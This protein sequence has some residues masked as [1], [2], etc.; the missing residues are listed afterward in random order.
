MST[1]KKQLHTFSFTVLVV[2]VILAG[3]SV[4]SSAEQ[5][6][7]VGTSSVQPD[8]LTFT[9]SATYS[10]PIV[11]PPGRGKATPNLSLNYN[12][13]N[14]NSWVGMGWS[15][16]IGA[17]QRSTKHG[18]DY[19]ADDYIAIKDG[20]KVE[21]VSKEDD[22]GANHF[23]AKIEGAFTKFKKELDDDFETTGGFYFVVTS[24]DGT[25]FYYG[26]D[27]NSRL[28]GIVNIGEE[29]QIFKWCLD[30][31]VDTNGNTIT[32]SYWKYNYASVVT[33]HPTEIKYSGHEVDGVEDLAPHYSVRF[34]PF[35]DYTTSNYEFSDRPDYFTSFVP[36]MSYSTNHLLSE[37]HILSGTEQVRRYEFGYENEGEVSRAFTTG[38]SRL[39]KITQ[40]GAENKALPPMTFGYQSGGISFP[41]N[42]S[43]K[44][45][46]IEGDGSSRSMTD[47]ATGDINGDGRQDLVAGDNYYNYWFWLDENDGVQWDRH[48]Q[49]S[50]ISEFPSVIKISLMDVNND[51]FDDLIQKYNYAQSYHPAFTIRYGSASAPNSLGER[52][53]PRILD[54][55]KTAGNNYARSKHYD[56]EVQFAD[57]DGDG[58]IDQFGTF[59]N[60]YICMFASIIPIDY[61]LQ[62]LR[63]HVEY[64]VF[65][66]D[67]PVEGDIESNKVGDINGDGLAD[68]LSKGSGY[69]QVHLSNGDGT[70]RTGSQSPS[71]QSGGNW[72]SAL[73]D[74][75]G[76]GL[77]DIIEFNNGTHELEYRVSLGGGKFSSTY[78]Y[79]MPDGDA[80]FA[81][82]NGD[83][84]I[85]LI[86][87]QDCGACEEKEFRISLSTGQF[88]DS[89]FTEPSWQAS[90]PLTLPVD[91]YGSALFSDID[92]DGLTDIWAFYQGRHGELGPN[93]VYMP[94]I[95][96]FNATGL[97][98]D[99]LTT[100]ENGQGAKT[101]ITYAPT[102]S[103]FDTKLPFV[104]QTVSKIKTENL[105][106]SDANVPLTTTYHYKGGKYDFVN[107][108]FLGFEQV[109]QTNP[110]NTYVK[111]NYGE[112]RDNYYLK[113][114]AKDVYTGGNSPAAITLGTF[115]NAPPVPLYTHTSNSWKTSTDLGDSSR[116]V[117]LEEAV[118][119]TFDGAASIVSTVTNTYE[120]NSTYWY[121]KRSR[122]QDSGLGDLTTVNEFV[123]IDEDEGGWDW[124]IKSNTTY[125]G[126]DEVSGTMVRQTTYGYV[127][128]STG[129]VVTKE[130]WL[131]NIIEGQPS[132]PKITM[133][134]DFYGNMDWMK[135]ANGNQAEFEYDTTTHTF[136]TKE[137]KPYS[138][139]MVY[140]EAHLDYKFGVFR[141][142]TNENGEINI[143]DYDQFGRLI[144]VDYPDGG[145]MTKEYNLCTNSVRT[146]TAGANGAMISIDYYDGLGRGIQ[147]ESF[148]ED[149]G[150]IAVQ[151]DFSVYPGGRTEWTQGPFPYSGTTSSWSDVCTSE[152]PQN[153]S[154]S[155]LKV[156]TGSDIPATTTFFDNR[157][158]ATQVYTNTGTISYAYAIE[159]QGI[160]TTV[161]DPDSK[162]K[163][164]LHDTR[165][166]LV[167]VFEHPATSTAPTTQYQ[168]KITGELEK[169][170]DATGSNITEITYD[171]L[172]RKTSM[173]DPDMGEWFYTQYDGNGN[174]LKQLDAMGQEIVM[175]YDNLNR[176]RSKTY[177]TNVAGR[178]TSDVSYIYANG[179]DPDFLK[180][181]QLSEVSH[182]NVT[183]TYNSYDEMGRLTSLTKSI[184]GSSYT[185]EYSYYDSGQVH[186]TTYPDNY[187]VE[188][189]YH[190]NTGR[191]D[192]VNGEASDASSSQE[193][194]DFSYNSPSGLVHTL[195]FGNDVGSYD[196]KWCLREN[197]KNK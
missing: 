45:R 52:Y 106:G 98:P 104:L 1:L 82:L 186:T 13:F 194:A 39:N 67:Y 96:T 42:E 152:N 19:T 131:D 61:P 102:S 169:V 196:R 97:F 155:Y 11:V 47:V 25:K 91:Q 83:G 107:R 62:E 23:G 46:T 49:M 30:K 115:N 187:E 156:G 92:G 129:L 112:Y 28:E 80:H 60:N 114:M 86:N 6:G 139:T 20:G 177:T 193:L 130:S 103:S 65:D 164:E 118:N 87:V 100:I 34:F 79:Q 21:L 68:F 158:R 142:A 44:R 191:L 161:T 144:R 185:T 173:K 7:L 125:A 70:F 29:K 168:Y 99:L 151:N 9:G 154:R 135:D 121:L 123:N 94:S 167:K 160:K 54:P 138:H 188:Y 119:T 117:Y 163:A 143:S 149:G 84:F 71:C 5:I 133:H 8:N 58:L 32:L 111:T 124:R 77:A 75:S 27:S 108:E 189:V 74:L 81:D 69:F 76:D 17:I 172:G 57:L 141:Q 134:Y 73:I 59:A 162:K 16:D 66:P 89:T 110:D 90:N 53:R 174:L 116:F 197:C 122:K 126:V 176:L 146:T 179:D 95:K 15:L 145:W 93:G 72:S 38:R 51:G 22:W 140:N 113:G 171:S 88:G 148:D 36:Q 35:Y 128:D 181:G 147:T 31:I 127:N 132:N 85:D 2:L 166:R 10:V 183:T 178:A 180:R 175:V 40:Y 105:V 55:N 78:Q 190:P 50:D 24:S 3:F 195:S 48:E 120:P 170:I 18:V 165:G 157:G 182:G 137:T 136:L 56:I 159:E 14:P 37:I 192:T 184:D 153:Y 26:R 43:F 150:L 4:P 101:T 12:S 41:E 109:F 64:T 63:G 33:I